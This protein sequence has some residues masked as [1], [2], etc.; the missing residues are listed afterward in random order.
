MQPPG[1]L[2]E[3]ALAGGEEGGSEKEGFSIKTN[4]TAFEALRSWED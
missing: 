2:A 1:A 4:A 3:T